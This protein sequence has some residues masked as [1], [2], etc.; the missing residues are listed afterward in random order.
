VVVGN[1]VWQWSIA[2][3]LVA[4]AAATLVGCGSSPASKK[5]ASPTSVPATTSTTSTTSTTTTTTT[6]TTIP[7]TSSTGV[8]AAPVR[9]AHT[10][11]GA[12]TYR[13]VG[14]GTPLVLIMG[15]GGTFDAW[16][17]SFL[18]ALAADY[19]VVVF[20]NAGIGKTAAL[21]PPLSI[22][23]MADQTSALISALGL[24]RPDVLGWSMGG[25]IA[26]ALAVLHPAQV[27][28]LVLAASQPGTGKAVPVPTA[29]AAA[30]LSPNA[31]AVLNVLFPANQSAAEQA[32]LT[33][34]LQ[35][36]GFFTVPP[37]VMK[38]QEAAIAGWF[39]GT[40]PA[41]PRLTGVRVPTLVADGTV[42][43]L[44]PLANDR[45]LVA[46]I[47]GAQLALYADAGHAFLFQ[48]AATF[49]PRL[50]RFLG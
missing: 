27:A 7:A 16:A 31:L 48:D 43:A 35:Y 5:A 45:Q 11:Y 4:L 8:V 10:A 41:G 32:Y 25:M 12:V 14:H 2:G 50:Q 40:D 36:P 13:E 29:A 15:F 30:L 33:G 28:R 39:A 18:N 47:P 37:A 1:R 49:L 38:S 20:N 26:Q 22:S 6:T 19:R 3:G 44:D 21:P 17:P 46:A 9:V 23:A 24:G 34:I 42:D